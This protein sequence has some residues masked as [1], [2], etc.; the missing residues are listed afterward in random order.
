VIFVL[1]FVIINSSSII[2]LSIKK[3]KSQAPSEGTHLVTKIEGLMRMLV[4]T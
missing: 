3:T 1:T 2:V 4:F